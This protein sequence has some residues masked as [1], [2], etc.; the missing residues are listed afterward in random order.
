MTCDNAVW[1][2]KYIYE[3]DSTSEY[4]SLY[5]KDSVLEDIAGLDEELLKQMT[6]AID[7][8][9]LDKLIKLIKSIESVKPE[10]SRQLMVLAKDYDYNK[11]RLIL[12]KKD[13]E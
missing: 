5:I 7:V 6:D 2:L 13:K 9:D 12:G 4:E 8:A 1:V 11:L 3:E 10:L